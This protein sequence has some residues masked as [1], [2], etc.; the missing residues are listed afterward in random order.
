MF[1]PRCRF[2]IQ[3]RPPSGVCPDCGIN[4]DEAARLYKND[5]PRASEN[6]QDVAEEADS[7]LIGG[8]FKFFGIIILVV[9]GAALVL[10]VFLFAV[11]SGGHIGT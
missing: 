9:L 6:V 8:I 7:S 4:L 11:C 5:G 2:S 10:L 1:C 3:N